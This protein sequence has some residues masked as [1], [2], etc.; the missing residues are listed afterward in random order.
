MKTLSQ[1]GVLVVLCFVL[2]VYGQNIGGSI[3]FYL[4]LWSC[5][6]PY[7]IAVFYLVAL[8]TVRAY[9]AYQTALGSLVMLCLWGIVIFTL[10]QTTNEWTAIDVMVLLSLWG[11]FSFSSLLCITRA[12]D[13]SLTR[14]VRAEIVREWISKDIAHSRPL[15]KIRI[16]KGV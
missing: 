4:V 2:A 13:G 14:S 6:T 16:K 11:G 3:G 12:V 9:F 7:F 15:P 10:V 8:L 1:F 5:L